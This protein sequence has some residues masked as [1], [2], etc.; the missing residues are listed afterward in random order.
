MPEIRKGGQR[1][2]SLAKVNAFSQFQNDRDARRS[3]MGKRDL[4]RLE[5]SDHS[6]V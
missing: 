1:L 6:R 5:R 3:G 2:R 4:E